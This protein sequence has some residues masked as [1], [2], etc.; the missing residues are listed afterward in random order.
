MNDELGVFQNE[1]GVVMGT[2]SHI[3][4]VERSSTGPDRPQVLVVSRSSLGRSLVSRAK[5]VV[6][7]YGVVNK[8]FKEN[9]CRSG[10]SLGD[11]LMD[12]SIEGGS[13]NEEE[14]VLA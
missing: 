12:D 11:D 8:A 10:G 4:T 7:P 2:Q 13:H 3:G 6:K 1:N 5:R 14:L 9:I